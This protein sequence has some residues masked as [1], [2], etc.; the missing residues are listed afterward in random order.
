[1][2]LIEKLYGPECRYVLIFRHGLDVACSMA[3]MGIPKS[4]EG[5]RTPYEQKLGMAATFWAE[6]CEEIL[7][8]AERHR[9]RCI[10]LR[11]EQ[12]CDEP[13]QEIRRLFAFLDEPFEEQVL[14]FYR[15]P[16]DTWIGLQ[17]GKAALLRGF[18]ANVERGASVNPKRYRP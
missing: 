6:R 9:D 12:L 18:S 5:D 10:E 8:F 1:M 2:D 11:Y 17:D 3:A 15:Q 13:E 7:K 14:Q 16:H 4:E